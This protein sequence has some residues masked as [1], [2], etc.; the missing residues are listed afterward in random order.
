M[1]YCVV[2]AYAPTLLDLRAIHFKF[3]DR[4]KHPLIGFQCA[5]HGP[6]KETSISTHNDVQWI[7]TQLQEHPWLTQGAYTQSHAQL[8]SKRVQKARGSRS[9]SCSTI[10]LFTCVVVR[11]KS[12]GL[13]VDVSFYSYTFYLHNTMYKKWG[14]PINVPFY[15]YIFY[16]IKSKGLLIRTSSYFSYTIIIGVWKARG[17]YIYPGSSTS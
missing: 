9:T 8:I 7:F 13:L 16:S 10:I 6:R 15:T 14:R 11:T 17:I 1:T 5:T 3:H 2:L 4:I 12:K